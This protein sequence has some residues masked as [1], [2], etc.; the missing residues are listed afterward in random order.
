MTLKLFLGAITKFLLGVIIAKHPLRF[1]TSIYGFTK[2]SAIIHYKIEN[3]AA[4]LVCEIQINNDSATM[5]EQF[6]GEGRTFIVEDMP[7]TNPNK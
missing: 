5:K 3:V 1:I 7:Y 2:N 6:M 4:P